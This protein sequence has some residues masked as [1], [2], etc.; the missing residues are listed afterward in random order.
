MTRSQLRERE[1]EKKLKE[2][3]FVPDDTFRACDAKTIDRF[4]NCVSF[5]YF[6]GEGV[7]RFVFGEFFFSFLFPVEWPSSNESAGVAFFLC[8]I[9]LIAE[10]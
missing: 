5:R 9:V 2:M 10:D 6:L 4:T 3:Q 1:R 8:S 7:G